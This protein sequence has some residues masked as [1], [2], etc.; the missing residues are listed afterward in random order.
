MLKKTVRTRNK[1]KKM[2]WREEKRKTRIEYY[3]IGKNRKG[4]NWIEKKGKE[5][6]IDEGNC[7]YYSQHVEWDLNKTSKT[8][9][10]TLT[11]LFLMA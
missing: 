9:T 4:Y 1:E 6:K 10:E 11:A 3:R 5:L 2:Q 8:L 7:I